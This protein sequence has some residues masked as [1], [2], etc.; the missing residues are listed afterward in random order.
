MQAQPLFELDQRLANDSLWVLDLALSQLRLM[1]DA[2]FFWALLV[3][4]IANAHEWFALSPSDQL[5]LHQET[6]QVGRALKTAANAEKIN[7]GALGNVVAQLHVH[8]IA[9]SAA[10]ACWP[11]PVWGTST[12]AASDDLMQQRTSKLMAAMQLA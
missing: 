4:R 8:V 7:I 2:R 3:P 6:M 11:N 10:D 12:Q 9:R 1:Q 5:L